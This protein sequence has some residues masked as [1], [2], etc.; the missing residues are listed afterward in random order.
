[1]N[2]KL[3]IIVFMWVGSFVL[4]VPFGGCSYYLLTLKT[5]LVENA[6]AYHPFCCSPCIV[7]PD[8]RCC[9]RVVAVSR[10]KR[11]RRFRNQRLANGVWPK[12]KRRLE[13]GAAFR[14][15]I[16]GIDAQPDLRHRP[17]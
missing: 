15:F 11:H 14:S 3:K 16:A 7:S 1:M 6:K 8:N 4:L 2:A 12:Q 13:N 5:E 9:R 10:T 17:Q